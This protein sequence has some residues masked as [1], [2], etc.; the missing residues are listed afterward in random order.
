MNKK[1]TI[2][3]DGH[4]ACGKS[5]LAKGMAAKLNYVFIDSGAMYRGAA[6]FALRN[7][8]LNPELDKNLLLSLLD[9]LDLSFKNVKG[10]NCLFLG[11]EN[12]ED[13]IRQP[14]VAAIVSKV[15]TIKEVRVKLVA[16]QQEMGANGG[17]VMDGRDIGSVVFPNAEL[18]L[19]VTASTAIRSKR[20]FI[21]LQGKGINQDIGE[22]EKNLIERDYIDSTR[23]E[24]PL[25][26]VEDAIVLD[27]SELSKEE[28]LDWALS[29]AF[30][31]IQPSSSI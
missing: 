13:E 21:E 14:H 28:Q 27:N 4:S 6:L 29:K 31:T 16:Q 12:I 2:A 18:K 15:A 3:I 9:Q 17:I 20:R 7:G 19:F 25:I 26:Q 8:C 5:T 24:S 30:D 23:E 10:T 11:A 1:I 22:V